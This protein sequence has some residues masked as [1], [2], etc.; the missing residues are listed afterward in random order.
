MTNLALVS[1]AAAAHLVV[2]LTTSVPGPPGELQARCR[3]P[4]RDA[5]V[6]PRER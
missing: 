1:A 2:V 6:D 4:A 3:L 5:G